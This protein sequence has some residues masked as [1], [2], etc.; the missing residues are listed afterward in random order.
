MEIERAYLNWVGRRLFPTSPSLFE[1]AAEIGLSRR[2]PNRVTAIEMAR[3]VS[4]IFLVHDE[5]KHREC[6]AC[7]EMM[8]CPECRA[9][10]SNA[11]PETCK[12]CKGLGSV[13]RGAGGYIVIDGERWTYL[14][15]LKT[16]RNAEH[17]FWK[18]KH[19]IGKRSRCDRCSGLGYIPLGRIVGFFCPESIEYLSKKSDKEPFQSELKETGIRIVTPKDARKEVRRA[20]GSREAGGYYA[21]SLP[22][23]EQEHLH[24][25]AIERLSAMGN[26]SLDNVELSKGAV[27]FLDP[28]PYVRRQFRGVKRIHLKPGQE[29]TS[30]L[31]SLA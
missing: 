10:V 1:E 15:Y 2:L 13:E 4:L 27:R 26:I 29:L 25:Q 24:Q 11:D 14:R 30:A 20:G 7:A 21:M 19:V 16:K 22:T 31:G 9:D 23:V 5:G 28:I 12:V 8:V 18:D 6:L 3:R 17:V